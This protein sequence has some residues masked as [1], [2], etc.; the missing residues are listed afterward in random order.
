MLFFSANKEYYLSLF[1]HLVRHE[2]KKCKTKQKNERIS[3]HIRRI[4]FENSLNTL[5]TI[6]Q[7]TI[8]KHEIRYSTHYQDESYL[9]ISLNPDTELTFEKVDKNSYL[10]RGESNN[11]NDLNKLSETVSSI[12][13]KQK[14]K[15]RIELYDLNDKEFNYY[16]YDW[17]K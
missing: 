2:F 5:D 10:L 12:L 17:T 7:N 15:H 9:K 11:Q 13:S 6:F 8:L 3:I 1:K 4:V 16:N 14:I